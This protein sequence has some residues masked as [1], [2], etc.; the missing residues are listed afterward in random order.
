MAFT[1]LM[2]GEALRKTITIVRIVGIA[3]MFLGVALKISDSR[4]STIAFIT[5]AI[6]ILFARVNQWWVSYSR[7]NS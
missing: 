2:K 4:G 7:K 3:I 1:V 5:G 6:L